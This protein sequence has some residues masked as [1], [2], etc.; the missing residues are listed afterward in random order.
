[1]PVWGHHQTVVMLTTAHSILLASTSA[2]KHSNSNGQSPTG[3]VTLAQALLL[4]I[5]ITMPM[6]QANGPP[7]CPVIFLPQTP[8][9][10][11]SQV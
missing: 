7:C 8:E 2:W 5:P 4:D 6:C 10:L 11:G 3:N 9:Q 1:M